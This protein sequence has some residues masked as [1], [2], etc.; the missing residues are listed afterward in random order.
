MRFCTNCGNPLPEDAKKFCPNCGTEVQSGTTELAL[1]VSP[2][3]SGTKTKKK[4]PTPAEAPNGLSKAAFLKT[5]SVG[6]RNCI[7][8]AI[9][10][11]ICAGATTIVALTNLI[12]YIG[13]YALLDAMILLT[14]SLLV[15]LLRSR[16]AAVLLLIYAIY[17]VGAMLFQTGEFSGWLALVAGVTAVIGTFQCAKEWK[18]YQP[19]SGEARPF[20][21]AA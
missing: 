12:E 15:H 21:P 7:A 14:L 20:E 1:Y 9:V 2:E 4:K 5:Y 17:N 8:A 13:V 16:I 19:R 6:R 11:Y 18:E 10:G 3:T